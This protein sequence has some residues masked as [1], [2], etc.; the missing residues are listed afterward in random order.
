MQARKDPIPGKGWYDGEIGDS[1]ARKT[2]KR[3]KFTLQWEWSNK[4]NQCL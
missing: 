2:K 3:G 4:A 1:C